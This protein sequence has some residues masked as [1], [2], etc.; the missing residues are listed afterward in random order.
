MLYDYSKLKGKARE[1]GETLETIQ[2]KTGISARTLS[3]KWNGK[4]VFN[5]AEMAALKSLLELESVD[6]Y[7]FT[8]KL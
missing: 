4:G 1:K 2:R 7:F 6:E 3:A 5:Q 8:Q